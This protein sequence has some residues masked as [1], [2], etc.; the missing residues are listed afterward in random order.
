MNTSAKYFLAI[1]PEGDVY[2]KIEEIK[3]YCS[4]KYLTKGALRSPAHI[5]LHMPFE[6]K[7]SKELTLINTLQQFKATVLTIELE[8]YNCFEPRVVYIDVKP[9]E[10]LK[11]LQQQLVLFVKKHLGLFNQYE[12]KRGFSPHVTIAFRDL[13]KESFYK[14]WKEF[15]ELKFNAAFNCSSFYIM[16]QVNQQ[17]IPFHQITFN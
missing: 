17:W 7:A 4:S 13:K 5:T 2:N 1:V 8:N 14:V 10:L 3:K 15:N 16:K 11:L 6:W 12:D 9:N